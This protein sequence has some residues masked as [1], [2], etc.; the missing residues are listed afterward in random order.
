MKR[1]PFCAEEI[2]DAAIVCKHCGRDLTAT[3][4]A[5]VP[6]I[7]STR[8]KR[9]WPVVALG[10]LLLLLLLLVS[11]RRPMTRPSKSTFDMDRDWH[12]AEPGIEVRWIDDDAFSHVGGHCYARKTD[13]STRTASG[14]P[15]SIQVGEKY[16][17]A[18]HAKDTPFDVPDNRT[19]P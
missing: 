16:C 2:Q 11:A 9:V 14:Q 3:V 5:S 19:I 10:C 17:I 4:A 6:Q 12:P 8:R 15:G 13:G 7:V 1:C 18:Y